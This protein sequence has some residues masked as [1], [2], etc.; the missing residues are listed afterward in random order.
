MFTPPQIICFKK[1]PHFYLWY[2]FPARQK[3]T[4]SVRQQNIIFWGESGNNLNYNNY[5]IQTRE[6]LQRRK[7]IA[8]PEN[9]LQGA[10]SSRREHGRRGKAQIFYCLILIY[11]YNSCIP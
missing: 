6:I 9:R 10:L 8:F 5:S 3:I 4:P 11:F 1:L 2:N 7:I